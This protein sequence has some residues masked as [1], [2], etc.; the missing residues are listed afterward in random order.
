MTEPTPETPVEDRLEQ[1]HAPATTDDERPS[2]DP[3]APEAD[4]ME[5]AT[6]AAPSEDSGRSRATGSQS[7]EVAEGDLV[8]QSQEVDLD[9]DEPR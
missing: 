8:E 2:P 1:D 7:S 9:D 4:A 3:E 5:Q 6:T